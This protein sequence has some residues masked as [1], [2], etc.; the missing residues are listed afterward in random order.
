MWYHRSPSD[1]WRHRSPSNER[2]RRSI[3]NVWYHDQDSVVAIQDQ[4]AWGALTPESFKAVP[5]DGKQVAFKIPQLLLEP[6]APG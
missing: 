1:E 5:C 4:G 6:A 3:N 2:Y